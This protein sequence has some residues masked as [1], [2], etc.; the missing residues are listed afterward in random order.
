MPRL[1]IV[2][3]NDDLRRAISAYFGEHGWHVKATR[4]LGSALAIAD[5]HLP[6]VIITELMLP[7]VRGYRFVDAYR[8]AVSAHR[9]RVIALTRMPDVLF[10]R[11]KE[12]GFDEVIAK[13]ANLDALRAL[14]EQR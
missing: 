13:P 12:I 10:A 6:H 4:T 5:V 14:A 8:R 9:V 11:A 2:E 1:L 7:D 3:D